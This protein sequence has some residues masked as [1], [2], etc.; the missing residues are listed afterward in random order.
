MRGRQR[1]E[2][3]REVTVWKGGGE[4]TEGREEGVGS[5][6]RGKMGENGRGRGERERETE[7]NVVLQGNYLNKDCVRF[8]REPVHPSNTKKRSKIFDSEDVTS[9]LEA[10][11][12]HYTYDACSENNQTFFYFYYSP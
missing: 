7:R 8:H 4:V 12:Y 3:E 5:E 11:N 2:E 1:E 10:F 6:G 9:F